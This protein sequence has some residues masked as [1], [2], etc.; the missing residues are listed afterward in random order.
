MIQP[1]WRI[2]EEEEEEASLPKKDPKG[3]KVDAM[4]FW[5]STAFVVAARNLSIL[6][7]RDAL[8]E[9]MVGL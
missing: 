7:I 4:V 8:R 1:Q 9:R 3:L 5:V 2:A 6:G